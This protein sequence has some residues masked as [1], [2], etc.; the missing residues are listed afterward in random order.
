[1]VG[2]IVYFGVLE[3]GGEREKGNKMLQQSKTRKTKLVVS[4]HLIDLL[5]LYEKL[6][7]SM[8]IT[9]LHKSP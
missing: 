7:N 1:M 3:G 4:I 5:T 8:K 6:W 9:T 2:L